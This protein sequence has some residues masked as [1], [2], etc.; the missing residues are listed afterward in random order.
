VGATA[1]GH[2]GTV[3][4]RAARLLRIAHDGQ[5]LVSQ[6]TWREVHDHLPDGVTLRDVGRLHWP[7]LIPVQSVFQLIAP[8]LAAEFPPLV[9]LSS[10]AHNLPVL[11]TSFVGHEDTLDEIEKL[12]STARLV[13]L[14]GAGGIGKTRLALAVAGDMLGVMDDVWLVEL[15]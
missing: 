12:L 4:N 2:S 14:T 3:A 6:A 8:D 9:S 11:L 7:G 13:T 10:F 1:D 15:A 5:V